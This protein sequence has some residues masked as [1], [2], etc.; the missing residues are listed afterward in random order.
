MEFNGDTSDGEAR[1]R[2]GGTLM[3]HLNQP[4]EGR[5]ASG[6]VNTIPS[7]GSVGVKLPRFSDLPWAGPHLH[8]PGER[9]SGCLQVWADSSPM[10]QDA[11]VWPSGRERRL[12]QGGLDGLGRSIE[13]TWIC[14]RQ[15]KMAGSQKKRQ[16]PDLGY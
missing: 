5:I 3:T 12:L 11:L 16:R 6:E 7:C 15:G 2:E 4:W 10:C 13:V 14:L 9:G 1:D 8:P